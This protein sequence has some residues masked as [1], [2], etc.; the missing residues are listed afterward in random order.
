MFRPPTDPRGPYPYDAIEICFVIK[1]RIPA[2]PFLGRGGCHTDLEGH[3]SERKG[4]LSRTQ[5]S[6]TYKYSRIGN[7][8]TRHMCQ[9][10]LCL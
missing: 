6:W 7:G 9:S 4:E 8:A 1:L 3:D 5:K 10:D 2:S